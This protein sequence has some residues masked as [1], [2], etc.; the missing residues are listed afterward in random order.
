MQRW[1]ALALVIL[2]V[3]PA[4]AATW[5]E[6]NK[7]GLAALHDGNLEEAEKEF[8]ACRRQAE[9]SGARYGNF[10]TTLINQGL[11]YDKKDNVAESEK[12]YK[13]ALGIYEKSFGK[14]AIQVSNALN[15]LADLYRHHKRYP[16]AAPLYLRAKQIREKVAPDHPDY[17]DTLNGL[18]DVYRKTGKNAD[19]A[20]LYTKVL[21][22]RKKAFGAN[23]PKT[24]KSLENLASAYTASGKID[25]AEPVYENLVA[26]RESLG[27]LEDPKV[28]QALEDMA[29]ALT[30]N[31]KYKKAESRY[32]RAL[33][34]R[35][36]NA[37]A[38]PAALA[39]CLTGYSALLR[40]TGLN[41]EAA[42]MEARAKKPAGKPGAKN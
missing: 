5:D 41:D 26:T 42:K 37:K 30:Q 33:A 2:T 29:A 34:I 8:S 9:K 6:H 1:F 15:G 40:K 16:E 38:D 11:L 4:F 10:A 18:A 14:D 25:M 28:A 23:H 20:I 36:K 13:E 27:G 35:E 12:D 7:T 31:G 39:N 3:Q 21:D 24:A 22:I 19:A 17:A 32:K